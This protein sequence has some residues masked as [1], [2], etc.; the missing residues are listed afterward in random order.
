MIR[1]FSLMV[2]I[3][4]Q[5]V[6]PQAD[7][8]T[9]A[10]EVV[11]VWG[12]TRMVCAR[13]DATRFARC[14][15]REA[16]RSLRASRSIRSAQIVCSSLIP[17]TMRYSIIISTTVRV[18]TVVYE[19]IGIHYLRSPCQIFLNACSNSLSCGNSNDR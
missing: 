9:E 17:E 7:S 18:R 11:L 14:P 8:V 4:F 10:T 6:R 5:R 1:A 16:K 2:D 12:A 19:Y 13:A 15:S 3:L